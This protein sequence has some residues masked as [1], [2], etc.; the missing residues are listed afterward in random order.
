MKISL[1]HYTPLD[2]A[3]KAIR[4]CY[5]SQSDNMGCRD[6]KLLESIIKNKHLSTIEH[7]YMTFEIIGI[8]RACLQELVRHRIA[9]YSVRSTRYTLR[10]LRDEKSFLFDK[11][12]A[13]K[14]LV[15]TGIDEVDSASIQALD[16]LR[17]CLQSNTNDVAKYALPESYKTNLVWTINTRSLR[18]FLELRMSSRALKEIQELARN[19]LLALPKEYELLFKDINGGE[20]PYMRESNTKHI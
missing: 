3:V 9:S 5:N 10:E 20:M 19:I 15:L 17:K 7:L 6:T 11:S 8:S 14:Y 2:I 18:N 13:S 16:N 4:T 12:R 1:L